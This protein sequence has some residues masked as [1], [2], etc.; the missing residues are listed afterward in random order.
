MNPTFELI[1]FT[2]SHFFNSFKPSPLQCE[3]SRAQKRKK[4]KKKKKKKITKVGAMD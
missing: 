4:E 1:S 2:S 3:I